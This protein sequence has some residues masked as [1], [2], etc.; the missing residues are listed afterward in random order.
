[1]SK[2]LLERIS[3]DDFYIS[4]GFCLPPR[5]M[6]NVLRSC[7]ECHDFRLAYWQGSITKIDIHL[8]VNSLLQMIIPGVEFKHQFALALISIALESFSD[9][10]SEEYIIDLSRVETTELSLCSSLA[11]ISNSN[12]DKMINNLYKTF[13]ISC[14]LKPVRMQNCKW[15]AV[16]NNSEKYEV[17]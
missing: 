14:D 15:E 11:K 12:R 10:F 4:L 9:N 7:K 17:A 5:A 3:S 8:F 2:D 1:M 16:E 6:Y 13:F